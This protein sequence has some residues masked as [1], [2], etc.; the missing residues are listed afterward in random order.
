MSNVGRDYF[1]GKLPKGISPA[2]AKAIVDEQIMRLQFAIDPKRT[3]LK[4]ITRQDTA[5][6]EQG[7]RLSSEQ[8]V[9]S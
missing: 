3:N 7:L 6:S 4:V 1:Y 8:P 9:R 5:D 2:E